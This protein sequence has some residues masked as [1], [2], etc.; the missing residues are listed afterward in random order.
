MPSSFTTNKNLELPANGEYVDTWNVPVNADM[1]VID[2]ALGG[3]TN[4]SATSGSV[5]LTTTQYQKLIL[6]ITGTL[7]G[8]VT[9]TIPAGIGGQWVVRNAT[10]GAFTVTI[11]SGGAGSSVVISQS[12]IQ[13]VYSDGTNIRS[14]GTTSAEVDALFASKN[15]NAG[16]GLT[17][18]GSLS[19]S[20]T[21]T[22]DQASAANWRQ[23]VANKLLNPNAVWSAMSEVTLTDAANVAWDMSLGFDFILTPTAN[24]VMDNP[25]NTKVGQKGR[26]IIQQDGTGGRTLTWASNFK[27][28]N[29]TAPTLSSSANAVDILYYDVRS[30]SY[31]IISLA[32]R[33]FA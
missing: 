25:T 15:V 22:A 11:A 16:T 29:G 14:I 5:T 13:T 18:G 9:Y 33:A 21:L 26:L 27:F 8:D 10:T 1:N 19:G 12:T 32:G 30:S 6:N 2:A 17:G 28:A 7:I 4:L 3:T 20:V 31:I 24:R 23:N